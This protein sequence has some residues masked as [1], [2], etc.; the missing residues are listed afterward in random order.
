M[1]ALVAL[2]PSV[3]IIAL[4]AMFEQ[5]VCVE[6]VEMVIVGCGKTVMVPDKETLAHGLTVLTV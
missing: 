3:Y 6:G 2:P 5:I 4:D 1:V